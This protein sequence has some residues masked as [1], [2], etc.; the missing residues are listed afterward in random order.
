MSSTVLLRAKLIA[1]YPGQVIATLTG[2]VDGRLPVPE[3]HRL[4][5]PDARPRHTAAVLLQRHRG[6]DR[7]RRRRRDSERHARERHGRRLRPRLLAAPAPSG[8]RDTA[9]TTASGPELVD[10]MS[11]PN[12]RAVA[13]QDGRVVK[14]GDSRKLGRY[15][16]L[17]DVYGDV[18]TYAGLGSIARSY[19]LPKSESAASAAPQGPGT[20][21]QAGSR[22][23]RER[24][25]QAESSP[26]PRARC[27]CS[28][29]PTIP[30]RSRPSRAPGAPAGPR[31]RWAL[32]LRGG[33][34]VTQ[35]TVLGRVDTPPEPGRP[36][37][38]RDPTSGRSGTIDPRAILA[39]W[40]QLD[41]RCIRRREGQ[42][43]PARRHRQRRVP[44][45]QEPARA[46]GAVR[47]GHRSCP[48]SRQEIASGAIDKRALAVL[49]SFPAAA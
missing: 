27:V 5:S 29:I 6:R 16:I 1:A 42:P 40:G 43:E 22:A 31:P 4:G 14:L 9:S 32:P 21:T 3:A 47:P 13:V 28:P 30:T 20:S 24:P 8:R 48:C 19:E 39:N 17:R 35:G 33:S 26:A 18:F 46:R 25:P 10:V 49:R 34:I 38:L 15:L 36:A 12:A 44:A 45:V 37:A 2:L 7:R 11:E 23:G 41:A